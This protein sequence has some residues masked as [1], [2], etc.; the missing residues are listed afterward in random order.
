M[1]NCGQQG[2]PIG[3]SA[4]PVDASP[5]GGL[6]YRAHQA[7]KAKHR[8]PNSDVRDPHGRRMGR[9]CTTAWKL[10]WG[11][12]A[13]LATTLPLLYMPQER[14]CEMSM[15]FELFN[16]AGSKQPSPGCGRKAAISIALPAGTHGH[17]AAQG[18]GGRGIFLLLRRLPDVPPAL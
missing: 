12:C 1:L 18:R 10:S 2:L 6:S 11:P 16:R 15:P 4:R 14:S 17:S 7:A 9:D 13:S 5:L 8:K 3:T